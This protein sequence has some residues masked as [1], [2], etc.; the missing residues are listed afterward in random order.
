[1]W[2]LQLHQWGDEDSVSGQWGGV[3]GGSMNAC[4]SLS[5]LNFAC[6]EASAATL[7]DPGVQSHPL[8]VSTLLLLFAR[9]PE[10]LRR[11]AEVGR[12]GPAS[13]PDAPRAAA[14]AATA[15]G[16]ASHGAAVVAIAAFKGAGVAAHAVC[17]RAASRGLQGQQGTWVLRRRAQYGSS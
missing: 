4:E 14:A 15:A 16:S 3:L 6:R 5:L 2:E 13:G 1:M 12:H 8:D 7:C 9:R 17:G 10:Q 11:R